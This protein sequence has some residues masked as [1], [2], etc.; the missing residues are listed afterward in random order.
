MDNGLSSACSV[1][2]DATSQLSRHGLA[3]R[4]RRRQG[5]YWIGTIPRDSW[6]PALPEGAQYIRGQP[7]LGATGYRHWQVLV[8]FTQKKS[9]AAVVR[10]FNGIGHWELSRSQAADS[11]VWKED[12]RDG[13]PFEFGTR[14]V[15]RSSATDWDQI[16]VEASAGL[17]DGIPSDVFIRYYRALCSIRADHLQPVA[18]VRSCTV[19]WGRTGTGKSRDAWLAA[20]VDAYSKDPRTKFWC[21]YRGQQN[22][23]ID[24]FR[25]GID[26]A[27]LLR[28]LDR[29]PVRVELKGSTYPLMATTF[30]ITSNLPPRMWYPD[31]DGET[32]CALERRMNVVEYE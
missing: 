23:I 12:T 11:Y 1:T 10:C 9:L 26:I 5:L 21:G 30:W 32:Y 4:E 14:R 31:L 25:G 15:R 24:E 6:I 19:L 28:W 13:E 3:A 2:S 17:F 20:G 16:R 18:A 7:E 8:A 29:Y 22:V 27:H